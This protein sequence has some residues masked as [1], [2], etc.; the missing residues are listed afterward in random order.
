M[1][2]PLAVGTD[3]QLQSLIE[4]GLNGDSAAHDALLNHACD[5]LLRL[6]RKMFHGYP[7]LRR[8]E[9][10]DD[11]FQ[12]SM[13]RLHRAMAEVQVESVRH[14]FNLA[15]VQVRREL[16]DLAKHHFG[17]EGNGA[18]HHTDGQPADDVGGALQRADEPD[19]L[20]GWSEF[21]AEVEKL[22]DDEQEVVNLVYYD[23]LTQEEAARVLGISFRTLKRRWQTI[24]LKL[25]EALKSD[26]Q[27]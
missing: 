15:A 2:Q 17:P 5:R 9:Q 23:G 26:G 20:S 14:F 11:V 12:N 18:K 27:G 4:R 21:H 7:N 3:T 19:D 13:V 1:P 8:W 22:N 10:T 24:K 16:L 25:Y 6:T